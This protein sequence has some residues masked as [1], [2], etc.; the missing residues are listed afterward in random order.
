[1]SSPQIERK[2]YSTEVGGKTVTVEISSIAEQANASVVAKCGG[3]AV[4]V[5][6][7]MSPK[8]SSADY[9]PLRVDYEERFYAAG[10]IIGSRFIR[11][12]SRP[13]EEAI[14]AGRLV[15]RVIRPLFD[16]RVRRE[17]QVVVTVLAYDEENEPEFAGLVGA[18]TALGISDIPWGGPAAGVRVVKIGDEII[19]N[20]DS[21]K[22]TTQKP[23][24]DAFLAGTYDRI[25]MVELGGD[26]AKESE[27]VHALKTAQEEINKLINFQKKIIEAVGK[28]KAELALYKPSQELKAEVQKFLSDKLEEAVYQPTKIEHK[29]RVGE[30]KTEL[31]LHLRDGLLAEG[32]AEAD[33]LAA[34]FLFEEA[35]NNLVHKNILE[36]EK[37]PDGR[38]L[39]EVRLLTAEVGLFPR[40]HG[41][42]LFVRGNTQALGI[43]TLAPPGA[44]QMIE[45]M[46]MTGKRRF[47]L[48]Y[49]FPPYSVGEI[50]SFRGPGRREIGHGSLARKAVE[51]IL[52]S[53]E[54]FPYTIRVVSEILSSNG[55]SS[56]ATVCASTLSLMDAGVPI[57][58]PA[59]GIAMGLMMSQKGGS[60]PEA[61]GTRAHASGGKD[62]YKVLTDI[63][64][65]EDHHGDM[66]LKAAGTEDGV[67]ALQ[68]DV[69]VEGLPIEI[70]EKALEEAREAR[71]HILK[72]M[73][74]IIPIPRPNLSPYVPVIARLAIS[75]EKI[76]TIIGPG[77][78]TINGLI[79]K[80]TLVG[81]DVEE[82]GS[83]FVSGLD[84]KNVDDAVFEIKALTREFKVG[85]FV[86]GKIIKLLDFGAIVDLGGGRD[87][88]IHISEFKEGFVKDIHEVAKAGDFVRAKVIRV[89]E[90][91]RIALSVK[92]L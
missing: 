70:I 8:D 6:V 68:M 64:G 47:M 19:V 23:K 26:D 34:D 57:K 85:E 62:T 91:G 52:P 28:P 87:G 48:H 76:G 42:A 73:K 24:F 7:V 37:R 30:L 46:E 25:N 59:A 16:Q 36:K 55:S 4:L 60:P 17:I 89:E 22:I 1:M 39:N 10:K 44:E 14:L 61:D 54:E 53:K 71:L 35:V 66:D 2:T 83:V 27:V 86:E 9:M 67:N 43:T 65:P 18:S 45:T 49:N 11:R 32:A 75:P 80:Y 90:D 88:M 63:Q 20:P 58:K 15:D 21:S 33:W 41:S 31:F 72:F 77:G 3:T 92:Q 50:G 84:K 82:D 38:K 81:I 69:K 56:M 79:R 29:S 13:S 74:S 5:T 51:P 40:T 78:R 12:E